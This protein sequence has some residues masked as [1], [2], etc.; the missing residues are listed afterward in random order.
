MRSNLEVGVCILVLV[1]SELFSCVLRTTAA[2]KINLA[3]LSLG[4]PDSVRWQHF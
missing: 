4:Y 2:L 3:Y 1:I